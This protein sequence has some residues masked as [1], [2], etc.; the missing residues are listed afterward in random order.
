MKNLLLSFFEK[1]RHLRNLFNL[2]KYL[3]INFRNT[4]TI[5]KTF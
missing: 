4:M 1:Y 3:P 2:K 5:E